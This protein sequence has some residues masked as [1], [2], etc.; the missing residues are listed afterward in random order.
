V[1]SGAGLIFAL[2]SA[3]LGGT[4]VGQSAMHAMGH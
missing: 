1:L 4:A 2:T 3:A